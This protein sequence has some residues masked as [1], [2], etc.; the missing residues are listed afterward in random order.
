MATSFED[1]GDVKA[2]ELIETNGETAPLLTGET[3]LTEDAPPPK[4]KY[5]GICQSCKWFRDDPWN[6]WPFMMMLIAAFLTPIWILTR[7]SG[8]S[9]SADIISGVFAALFA[10]YAANHFRIV[11]G[12]KNQVIFLHI[13]YIQKSYIKTTPKM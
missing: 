8:S 9:L 1:A 10:C 7:A 12:L 2:T 13:L 11:L 6:R 4:P 3:R 5:T